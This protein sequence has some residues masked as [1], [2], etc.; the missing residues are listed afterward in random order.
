MREGR[1]AGRDVLHIKNNIINFRGEEG[2]GE[3]VGRQNDDHV[4][5]WLYERQDS[6]RS[7][8]SD[9]LHIRSRL[10]S[11]TRVTCPDIETNETLPHIRFMIKYTITIAGWIVA[12]RQGCNRTCQRPMGGQDSQVLPMVIVPYWDPSD[13]LT[14]SHWDGYIFSAFRFIHWKKKHLLLSAS[15]MIP[16]F[17]RTRSK[18]ADT[19]QCNLTNFPNSGH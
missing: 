17:G 16:L 13:H 1:P 11:V 19:V 8:L 14:L 2:G 5:Y 4:G 9:C 6:G 18:R 10:V 7:A 12:G 3:L 15:L